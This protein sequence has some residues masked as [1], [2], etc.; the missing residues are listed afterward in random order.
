MKPWV[1]LPGGVPQWPLP[2]FDVNPN[3]VAMVEGGLGPSGVTPVT[4]SF[5]AANQTSA[6]FK[7]LAARPFEISIDGATPGAAFNVKFRVENSLDGTNWFDQEFLLSPI[8]TDV[9][10]Q[11]TASIGR[12]GVCSWVDGMQWRL[13]CFEY[14]S[15]TCRYRLSQ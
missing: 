12:F 14:T 5:T 4:G 2:T 6:I 8:N 9:R 3:G 1:N 7:P 10:Y 15:G 11:H 13:V